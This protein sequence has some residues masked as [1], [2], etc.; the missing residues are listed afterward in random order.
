[1]NF[2]KSIDR[3]DFF[4]YSVSRD[5]PL[6]F[7]IIGNAGNGESTFPDDRDVS[8]CCCKKAPE[9]DCKWKTRI[10]VEE[11]QLERKSF[12]GRKAF[13]CWER[14]SPGE[15]E[16]HPGAGLPKALHGVIRKG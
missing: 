13:R 1:M 16:V 10:P 5:L 15:K 2:Y 4:A 6:F 12:H 8:I 11:K 7:A 14:S 3:T 9:R